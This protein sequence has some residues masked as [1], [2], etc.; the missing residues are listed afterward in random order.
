M[1]EELKGKEESIKKLNNYIQKL[2]G[3]L[4][5]GNFNMEVIGQNRKLEDKIMN[6]EVKKKK[7]IDFLL[8]Y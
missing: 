1:G 6:L 7:K 8:L 3:Q 4:M 2:E 5:K